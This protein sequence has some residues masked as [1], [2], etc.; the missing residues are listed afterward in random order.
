MTAP[1]YC[2]DADAMKRASGGVDVNRRVET[3]ARDD[4]LLANECF[5]RRDLGLCGRF[6]ATVAGSASNR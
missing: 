1:A 2:A 3:S 6:L 5:S 4:V